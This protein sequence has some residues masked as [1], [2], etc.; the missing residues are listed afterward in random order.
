MLDK[1]KRRI[2]YLRVS[3]T[4]RCNLRCRYCMPEEGIEMLRH[5]QILNFDEITESVREAVK[6]G[7]D[8]VRITGGEPLVRRGIVDLVAMI[9]KIEGINDFAI[10]TNATLLSK[11]AADLKE[12]G[13]DRVNVSLDTLDADKFKELLA[14]TMDVIILEQ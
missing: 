8:K 6:L 3:V 13:L 10:T 1:Y 9:A 14:G 7:V 4:D 5:D 11:F 2:N 12:A